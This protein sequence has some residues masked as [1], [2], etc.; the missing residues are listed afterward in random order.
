MKK[1]S[2]FLVLMLI[3]LM[4]FISCN[5]STPT[6]E[7]AATAEDAEIVSTLVYSALYALQGNLD[8]VTPI[9]E[10]TIKFD[11]V[12]VNNPSTLEE[13][14]I[15]NGT[16]KF[17]GTQQSGTLILDLT[18]GTQYKGKGHTLYAKSSTDGKNIE[19]ELD[20]YKLTNLDNIFNSIIDNPSNK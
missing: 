15:L 4:L 6:K 19:I 10:N 8:G 2:S 20:G 13:I 11:N 7:R 17:E 1:L 14:C 3:A 18:T 9:S 16:A 5:G 12:K